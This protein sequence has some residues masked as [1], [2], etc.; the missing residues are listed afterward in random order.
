MP[1]LPHQPSLCFKICPGY[2]SSRL[3]SWCH[4]ELAFS[5]EKVS[6]LF[7][8]FQPHPPSCLHFNRLVLSHVPVA[9][10]HFVP[11][12]DKSPQLHLASHLHH[13]SAYNLLNSCVPQGPILQPIT[14]SHFS[15]FLKETIMAIGW[16]A[17]NFSPHSF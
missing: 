6:S 15:N 17:T 16:D 12:H 10:D 14:F 13:G 5:V 7:P 9:Q 4:P 8:L 3:R 1:L 2:S 11:V